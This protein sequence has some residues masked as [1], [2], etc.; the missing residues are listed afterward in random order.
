MIA[1]LANAFLLVYGDL[2]DVYTPQEAVIADW[3]F[4]ILALIAIPFY[5]RRSGIGFTAGLVLGLLFTLRIAGD[6]DFMA[7][8]EQMPATVGEVSYFA[9]AVFF[10][11]MQLLSSYGALVLKRAE[12][13]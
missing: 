7:A 8:V 11:F 13:I 6:P 9:V 3:V 1:L 10:S 5:F 12:L 4:A 2:S